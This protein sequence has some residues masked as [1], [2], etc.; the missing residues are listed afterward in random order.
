MK[1]ILLSFTLIALSLTTIQAQ[2]AI[3]E[4]KITQKQTYS[5]TN[6]AVNTQL[7]MLGDIS[8]T[9]FFKGNK[10]RS[11]LS[12]P[13][14]GDVVSI[15]DND[16]KKMLALMDNPQLGKKYALKDLTI[17]EEDLKNM[18]VTPSDDTKTILG[19][20]CKKYDVALTKS[21]VETKMSMYTTDKVTALSDQ[22]ALFTDKVN[23]FPM[24]IEIEA[25]QMGMDFTI[26]MEVT[27]IEETSVEDAKFDMT[28]PDGYEEMAN[29]N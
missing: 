12:S 23:G 28:V 6:E 15:I 4:G 2:K 21:G 29:M 7:A 22:T 17:S 3:K 27:S 18:T 1:K 8:I 5:S 13:M 19:Y 11:E 16:E 10:S 20:T 14:T 24:L 9:T 25:S 26:K